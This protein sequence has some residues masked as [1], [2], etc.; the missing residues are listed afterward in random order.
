M[1]FTEAE[2]GYL[3]TQGVPIFERPQPLNTEQSLDP[4]IPPWLLLPPNKRPPLRV[5]SEAD[6]NFFVENG[7]LIVRNAVPKENLDRIVGSIWNFL[8]MDPNDPKDWY[9]PPLDPLRAG[10]VECYH[11][12]EMWDNRQCERVYG[13]FADLFGSEKLWVSIDR[14]NVKVPVRD[15]MPAFNDDKG[16]DLGL[17]SI[18]FLA[19][20]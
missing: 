16:G 13:A 5:L 12:Q 6:L 1:P 11:S 2:R 3:V 7:Y 8:E 9:R 15:D 10:M 17:R 14:V 20:N 4:T 18:C 19:A